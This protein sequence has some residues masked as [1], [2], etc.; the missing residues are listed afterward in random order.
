MPKPIGFDR[1][2]IDARCRISGHV[3]LP[4][5]VVQPSGQPS[6]AI[7][8]SCASPVSRGSRPILTSPRTRRLGCPDRPARVD[9]M[10]DRVRAAA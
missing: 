2:N 9:W 6:V 5:D 10:E 1:P 3:R 8:S 4:S 7:D